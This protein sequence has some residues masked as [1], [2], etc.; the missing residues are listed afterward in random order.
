MDPI[1]DPIDIS[2]CDPT[3]WETLDCQSF[4]EHMQQN[5]K[6]LQN[7]INGTTCTVDLNF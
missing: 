5:G 7:Y 4:E 2:T 3:I 6:I 1:L